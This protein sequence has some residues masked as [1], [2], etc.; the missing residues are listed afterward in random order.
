MTGAVVRWIQNN[1]VKKR[2]LI[3]KGTMKVKGLTNLEVVPVGEFTEAH[4][5]IYTE[6]QLG[7]MNR[8]KRSNK[9]W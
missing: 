8:M 4:L 3:E 2:L 6:S 7:K 5:L 9:V 1:P